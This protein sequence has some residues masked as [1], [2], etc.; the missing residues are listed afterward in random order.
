MVAPEEI[1]RA[2]VFLSSDQASGITG[3]NLPVD[4]GWLA[5]SPWVAYGGLPAPQNG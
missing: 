5:G 1:A 2:V 3:V 4:G